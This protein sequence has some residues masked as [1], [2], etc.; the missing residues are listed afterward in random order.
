M[1]KSANDFRLVLLCVKSNIQ[2][3]VKN[4]AV[5]RE[6]LSPKKIVI[7]GARDLGQFV[8][9]DDSTEFRDEDTI[10]GGLTLRAVRDEI[11]A[12]DSGAAHR[13]GWY[14]QQFLKLSYALTSFCERYLVWDSDTVPLHALQMRIGGK[15][16][17]DV[18]TEYNK[19][20]FDTLGKILPGLGKEHDFS[21]ISEHMI[22]ESAI[23]REMIQKIEGGSHGQ[24]WKIILRSIEK[25]ELQGSAFSEFETYGTYTM[26]FHPEA[27]TV[28][29]WKSFREEAVF[30]PNGVSVQDFNK[31]GM[32]YDA[33][34]FENHESQ[35]R[36]SK[37]LGHPVFQ[38]RFFI[39]LFLWAKDRAKK[40][41]M[42]KESRT[43]A[44]P[45]E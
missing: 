6:F 33:K 19:A 24:F 26:K 22:F 34:S 31:L 27:Y 8:P 4:L 9:I 45:H 1:Q 28:R 7:I 15:N 17:F 20:Y 13:A 2:E 38:N 21:F 35:K 14:F 12:I 10:L 3:T 18:K 37:L 16:V 32:D 39:S 11:G 25:G 43:W 23:V 42:Q 44:A 29:R 40:I 36:L 30:F 5:Y 41:I